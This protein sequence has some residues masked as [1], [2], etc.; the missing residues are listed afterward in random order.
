MK[1]TVN[2]IYTDNNQSWSGVVEAPEGAPHLEILK[3][4]YAQ[5]LRDNQ[6]D[7]DPE[8]DTTEEEKEEDGKFEHMR[9]TEIIE[10][11]P[12]FYWSSGYYED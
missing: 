10:G 2:G 4:A 11:E 9:F 6:Y 12:K 1:Y 7:T 3:L 8:D 5:V